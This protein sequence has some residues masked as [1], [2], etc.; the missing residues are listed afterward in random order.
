MDEPATL[1]KVYVPHFSQIDV[2]ISEHRVLIHIAVV[3]FV[4]D[5][6]NEFRLPI[7]L[8]VQASS[9]SDHLD[10]VILILDQKHLV[11]SILP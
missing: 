1:V 3:V 4:Q 10:F 8:T 11:V 9:R 5:F 6:V 2:G 7:D